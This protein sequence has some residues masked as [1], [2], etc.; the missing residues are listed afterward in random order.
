MDRTDITISLLLMT[1]SR[2]QY[3]ELA[4]KVGL[5][6]NAVHKR[7]KLMADSGIIRAF[8]ARPSLVSLNAITVWVC[9]RSGAVHPDEVHLRLKNN[10]STYWVA[11][12]GGGYVYVGGYLKDLSQLDPFVEF[13]NKEAEMVEPTVGIMPPM[14]NGPPRETLQPIDYQILASLH[15][16]ARKPVTD[17]A[18][19]VRAGLLRHRRAHVSLHEG[20]SGH[21]PNGADRLRDGLGEQRGRPAGRRVGL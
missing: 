1:D 21:K 18:S 12:S 13:V 19:E 10:E 4:G 16:D 3:H 14:T 11:N 5:S 8:T 7:I 17:V 9:G 2:V 6:I 20:C 15:H